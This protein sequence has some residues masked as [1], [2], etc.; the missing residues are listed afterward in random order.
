MKDKNKADAVL[1]GEC[2]ITEIESI[3]S[4]A[5]PLKIRKTLK[6]AN[7]ETTG[8]HHLVENAEGCE[9]YELDGVRYMRNVQPTVVKCV[10]TKRHDSVELPAGT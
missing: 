5:A 2:L 10:D 3:P 6:I 7:S 4:G 8:N 9:F 1:H